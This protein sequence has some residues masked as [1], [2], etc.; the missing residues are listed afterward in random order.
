MKKLFYILA[1]LLCGPVACFSAFAQ[2]RTVS[3]TVTDSDGVPMP[4]VSV[5]LGSDG[6]V[7][8]V[9]DIDGKWT[10]GLFG[11]SQVIVFSFLGMETQEVKVADGQKVINVTMKEAGTMLD[12]VVITGYT[13]TSTKKMTGSVEVLTTKDLID[14]P[15]SSI[16]AMLQGQLAGVSVSATSGQPG[17]TQEIRIRGQATLTG[18]QSPLWVVD[19]VPLQGGM[20]NVS[21]SQLKTGGL[22]DFLIN[23]V[24]DINPNDIENI[25]ILKDASAAAIYGSR[26][27]N[28]VIVVTTKRGSD[29]PMHVNYSGNVSVTFRP[30]R[31]AALMNSSEK[32]DWEQE[33]W[34][35]FSAER[36][37][38]ARHILS[39]ESSAWC[40]PATG[41]TLRWPGTRMRRTSILKG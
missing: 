21:D 23:G 28:G 33:L 35:E 12:Q 15:Q 18:D 31:D 25:S 24:G 26:A 30:Q 10:L 11:K 4:G 6:K 9:T 34:D 22:E 19:G 16:D 3:G 17:R 1:L 37:G 7:G 41:S 29:G 40:A 36:F 13:Q 32:I 8:A 14:K 5:M 20:P 39:S 38:G 2:T 27:A